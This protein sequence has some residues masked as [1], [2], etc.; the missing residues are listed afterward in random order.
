MNL[1][2]A[3]VLPL[4]FLAWLAAPAEA[5]LP[6]GTPSGG[7]T[8][9]YGI[10]N[11][12]GAAN[13]SAQIKFP[14]LF[15]TVRQSS[16]GQYKASG[17][18][19]SDH[20]PN[21]NVAAVDYPVG[22]IDNDVTLLDP[23]THQSDPAFSGCSYSAASNA[24]TCG[25]SASNISGYYFNGIGV[26]KNNNDGSALTFTNN[27]L[28]LTADNCRNF[29]GTGPLRANG[30]AITL[31]NNTFDFDTGCV[32][33]A[34]NYKTAGDPGLTTQASFTASIA[35]NTMT[36][37]S[38]ATGKIR[39]F[40][41]VDFSGRVSKTQITALT[42]PT[43]VT[44]SSITISGTTATVTTATPH[45]LAAGAGLTMNTQTPTGYR[46]NI[47]VLAAP[48]STHFTYTIPYYQT[49][50]GGSASVV[51]TYSIRY[52]SGA[53]ANGSTWTVSGTATAGS[54]AFTTGPVLPNAN[55]PFAGGSGDINATYNAIIGAGQFIGTGTSGNVLAKYNYEEIMTQN[56]QHV[57]FIF[58][59]PPGSPIT[60]DFTMSGNTIWWNPY[61]EDSGTGTLDLFTSSAAASDSGPFT[62]DHLNIENNVVVANSSIPNSSTNTAA[63]VRYLGQKGNG[64][65]DIKYTMTGGV[66]TVTQFAGGTNPATIT[67]GSV[68]QCT[69]SCTAVVQFIAQLTGTGGA[70]CPDA[71]CTGGLGTYSVTNTTDTINNTGAT[72]R[73]SNYN[74]TINTMNVNGNYYDATG[75]GAVYNVDKGNTWGPTTTNSTGNVNMLTGASCNV[76]GSC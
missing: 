17:G 70:A 12:C 68:V 15:T 67:A 24:F 75:A 11:G 71:T 5:W 74:G 52:L 4:L 2:A 13:Q 41:Y 27:H 59:T 33:N 61:A 64:G 20:P 62:V 45:G 42:A 65:P 56:A 3:F 55:G 9:P 54:A 48:D 30:G 29:Q 10:D 32:F 34:D 44:I 6:H 47:E 31:T 53:A 66:L 22:A 69:L 38:S 35:A 26:F 25:N 63:L 36:V 21:F 58:N 72:A 14:N 51:G 1:R 19:G 57:N 73:V 39:L 76:G 37:S 7:G 28:T 8:C 23:L 16:Q 50:P 40:Q 43:P 46:G 18:A 49:T 60:V